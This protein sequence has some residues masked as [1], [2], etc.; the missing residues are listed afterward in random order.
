MKLIIQIG[1]ALCVFLFGFSFGNLKLN[2]TKIEYVGSGKCISCHIESHQELVKE[3]ETSSHHLTMKVLTDSEYNECIAQ[4]DNKNINAVIGDCKSTFVFVKNDYSL[5]V[6]DSFKIDKPFPPHKEIGL[7]D[8]KVDASQSCLGCHAT[9]YF[10]KTRDYIEPGVGCEACHG[11]G[12]KHIDTDGSPEAIINPAKISPD[13]NRMICGQCHSIGTDISGKHPFPVKDNCIPFQPGSELT[14]FFVDSKPVK[15]TKGAEYSTF[16]DSPEPFSAQLCTDCHAP[17]GK[18]ENP[19]MLINN[20]SILC[21]KCHSNPLRDIA[22][23]DEK[24]HWGAV[25]YKC[26]NCHEYTHIH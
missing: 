20:D 24:V 16:V 22:Y 1:I 14:D 8:T 12:K 7:I 9:G 3:W 13:K 17:H 4:T 19:A 26:W 23:V 5:I 21:K 11:P 18:S 6:P 25:R 15:K 10:V 2:M